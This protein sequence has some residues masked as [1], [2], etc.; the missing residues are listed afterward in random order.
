MY[1]YIYDQFLRS[2]KLAK[3]TQKIES[4]L[5]QLNISGPRL[6]FHPN[7][8]FITSLTEYCEKE[9]STIVVVGND[10]TLIQI[11]N[12]LPYISLNKAVLKLLVVGYIPVDNTSTLKNFL[13]LQNI[14]NACDALASRLIINWD[15][16]EI[17]KEVR[18]IKQAEIVGATEI[19]LNNEYTVSISQNQFAS[20]QNIAMPTDNNDITKNIQPDDKMLNLVV[21]EKGM[22]GNKKHVGMFTCK[23][24][25]I[26]NPDAQ[27]IADT[28]FNT[29]GPITVKVING[30]L[31]I[32]TGKEF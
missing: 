18:F 8:T 4:R 10:L 15:L 3:T 21:Q 32:I 5:S 6:F 17:N 26:N 9:A 12:L 13:F 2:P 20:I 23:E 7:K 30:G 19:T 31:K 29:S 22:F 14:E 25:T 11:I 24:I 28:T 16:G 27:I 1:I